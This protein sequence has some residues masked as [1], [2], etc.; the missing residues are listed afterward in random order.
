M[1]N[2]IEIAAA[3][4]KELADS[5]SDKNIMTPEQAKAYGIVDEIITK[6]R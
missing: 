1:M 5:L 3:Q 2:R 4:V 6:H